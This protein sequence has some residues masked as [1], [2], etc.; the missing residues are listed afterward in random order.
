PCPAGKTL[1]LIR[2]TQAGG[3]DNVVA[4]ASGS[5]AS[6]LY[7]ALTADANSNANSVTYSVVAHVN[8]A[9]PGSAKAI[10]VASTASGTSRGVI[11]G[12][13]AQMQPVATTNTGSA[14][15]MG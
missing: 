13:N 7:S 2:L 14:N 5:L 9:G 8:N 12:V 1:S 4:P 10:H 11:V 15:F 3:G 6:G